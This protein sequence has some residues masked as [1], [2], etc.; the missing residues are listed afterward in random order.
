MQ[1]MSEYFQI[2]YYHIR[3]NVAK[4]IVSKQVIGEKIIVSVDKVSNPSG[5]YKKYSMK[6]N[7]GLKKI[8][9]ALIKL[10]THL[11]AIYTG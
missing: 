11:V 7:N 2:F 9:L 1:A 5:P 8:L 3:R 6:Q 10:S 4:N